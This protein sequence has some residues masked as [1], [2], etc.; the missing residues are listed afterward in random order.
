MLPCFPAFLLICCP[1]ILLRLAYYTCRKPCDE[2]QKNEGWWSAYICCCQHY[3]TPRSINLKETS[4]TVHVEWN[5][6]VA[7]VH[8]RTGCSCRRNWKLPKICHLGHKSNL[9]KWPYRTSLTTACR[10]YA[11]HKRILPPKHSSLRQEGHQSNRLN[12]LHSQKSKQL[13]KESYIIIITTLTL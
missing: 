1:Y 6:T 8:A 10:Q 4:P 5:S 3:L 11:R 2:W 9:P 7:A 13:Q 12:T